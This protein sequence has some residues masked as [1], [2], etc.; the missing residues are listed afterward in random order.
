MDKVDN[1]D[2]KDLLR[3]KES[4]PCLTYNRKLQ[5]MRQII[6]KRCNILQINPEFGEAFQ[7]NPFV[8]FK[9]SKNLQ[10]SIGSHA[11]KNGVFKTHLGII[12]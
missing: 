7:N 2:R 12:H 5:T 1:T 10:E 11:T 6:N 4:I 9:R 8:T 3:K